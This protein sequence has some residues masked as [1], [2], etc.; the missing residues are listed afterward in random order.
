MAGAPAGA[1]AAWAPPCP[2]PLRRPQLA[3]KASRNRP[4]LSLCGGA[5][6]GSDGQAPAQSACGAWCA[7]ASVVEPPIVN[8]GATT[9]RQTPMTIA[10]SGRPRA[11][12]HALRVPSAFVLEGAAP[13]PQ[14]AERTAVISAR[15][16][17][18]VFCDPGRNL[19]RGRRPWH[20]AGR[21]CRPPLGAS[22]RPVRLWPSVEAPNAQAL[23]HTHVA[24]RHQLEAIG[25]AASAV[26]AV[27]SSD[28]ARGSTH[29][30]SSRR[31]K[32]RGQAAG[33][34]P[35]AWCPCS[36]PRPLPP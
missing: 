13:R 6:W 21:G 5:C 22:R 16:F 14:P 4:Q 1:A 7:L 19:C 20:L 9:R 17:A 24:A 29:G 25:A 35:P 8:M 2:P 10:R 23:R 31:A 11:L 33:P 34:S 12:P 26:V 32:C 28:D 15:L 3:F 27:T 18:G 30:I 36:R